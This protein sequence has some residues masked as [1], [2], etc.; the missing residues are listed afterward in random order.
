[1]REFLVYVGAVQKWKLYLFLSRHVELNFR[2][3]HKAHNFINILQIS[4]WK[5]VNGC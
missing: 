4:F 1:M 3:L 2:L 5:T